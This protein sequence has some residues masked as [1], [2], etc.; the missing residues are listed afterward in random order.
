MHFVGKI[1]KDIYKCITEDIVTDEV[2]ITDEQI[3][4]IKDRHPDDY[5][6]IKGSISCVLSDP[7]YIFKDKHKNT[8]LIIKKIKVKKQ[9]LQM[10]L[11]IITSENER[12]YKNS[13]ISCWSISERR[14]QN[15][16]RNKVILYKRE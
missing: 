15:Y 16:L 10:V 12:A 1:N 14:L 4:H 9:C 5:K 2:F 6:K 7:D 8:G 3:Q 11:R 13:I